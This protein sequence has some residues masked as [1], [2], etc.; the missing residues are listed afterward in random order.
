METTEVKEN[1]CNCIKANIICVPDLNEK[2]QDIHDFLQNI[3]FH[4]HYCALLSIKG[5]SAI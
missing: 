4:L 2:Y 5:L 3:L 1:T